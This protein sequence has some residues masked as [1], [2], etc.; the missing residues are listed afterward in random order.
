M[1]GLAS[2]FL[3]L[4]TLALL[5]ACGPEAKQPALVG[6]KTDQ[7]EPAKPTPPPSPTATT[8]APA[9]KPATAPRPAPTSPAATAPRPVAPPTSAP[10][11][12]E[13]QQPKAPA[14]APQA[15]VVNVGKANMRE[16]ADTK[17][18]ILRVLTKGTKVVVVS[19]GDQW[20][21]VRLSDGTEGWLAESVVTPAPAN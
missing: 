15:L 21:R 12:Q 5:T 10:A 13:A 6:P 17:A 1:T 14:D 11:T 7:A 8:P 20:Y 19:K 3:M 18:K 9:P 16:R 2:R 4:G